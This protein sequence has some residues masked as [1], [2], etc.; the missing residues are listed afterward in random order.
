MLD[1]DIGHDEVPG[2]VLGRNGG[3]GRVVRR[4]RVLGHVSGLDRVLALHWTQRSAWSHHETQQSYVNPRADPIW[5]LAV[6]HLYVKQSSQLL[7]V[8]INARQLFEEF[9]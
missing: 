5:Q 3:H 2:H 6:L 7:C 1:Y 8:V 4:N 9:L